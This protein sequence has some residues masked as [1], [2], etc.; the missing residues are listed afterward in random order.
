M[1]LRYILLLWAAV[2]AGASASRAVPAAHIERP[3]R[4]GDAADPPGAGDPLV[5]AA[6]TA[7]GRLLPMHLRSIDDYAVADLLI[8]SDIDGNLHGLERHTGTLLWTL[9]INDPLVKV[10]TNT[11]ATAPSSPAANILWFVE[12]YQ[13]GALY[14]FTPDFGLNQLPTSIR[15]LVQESPFSLAADDK[16]YTGSRH[17][18]LYTVDVRTGQV[19]SSFG[20]DSDACPVPDSHRPPPPLSGTVMLGKTTYELQIHSRAHAN[21]VW[22]VTY[23][24]WGPNNIDNDL[25]W[26]NQ[27]SV[28]HLYFTPFHDRSLLGL[29][30]ES[31]TP[32]WVS[33]LP[34]LA[35]NVFD[36]FE[37][38]DRASAL[39]CLP[40]PLQQLSR[41]DSAN[42]LVFVNKTASS[43]EWFAMSY[44][45]YP[46]LIKSAPVS[47]F[48]TFVSGDPRAPAADLHRLRQ[49]QVSGA[50]ANDADVE[51]ALSGIHRVFHLTPETQY[52]PRSH[53]D[54]A[55]QGAPS[56]AHAPPRLGTAP[57]NELALTTSE[58]RDL[59]TTG[60]PSLMDG[61]WFPQRDTSGVVVVDAPAT[62]AVA[63]PQF[64]EVED[65]ATV[66]SLN[67]I[68]R[69]CEDVIVIL[70]LLVLLM[71][72]GRLG[73]V[74][75]ALVR[76]APVSSEPE[77]SLEASEP[78][79]KPEAGAEDDA[80]DE[81]D[82]SSKKK[83]K[84]GSRGGKRA[85]KKREEE[86]DET[87]PA[88]P[89]A[90]AAAATAATIAT[91][92]LIRSTPPPTP[93]RLQIENNLVLSDK[94][95]GY[96]SHGTVVF[97]GTFENRP[98]AVKRML[99][100]FFDI[101]S[102][103]VR[104]L[105]ESD[106]HPNVIRYFCSQSSESEKFLYIALE[107]CLCSLEEVV[108]KGA[109]AAAGGSASAAAA[110]A[111]IRWHQIPSLNAMLLQLASGLHYLHSLKI[112]HRDLKPQNI[113]VGDA[114]T[115]AAQPSGGPETPIRLLISDFGLC[116]KLEA[117][118]SSFRATAH[119]AASGT[120]GWRAPELLLHHDLVEISPE[121]V[122]SVHSATTSAGAG[123]SGAR[124]TKA[125]D[126]FSLGCVFF[127]ILSPGGHPFG[128]RYLREGNIIK[129]EY[130]LSALQRACPHDRVESE[131]LIGSM[132]S[133]DP[134]QRPD[135][136]QIMRHPF[137]WP[138][139]KRLEFL[140]RVSDRFE[141]ERRDPPSEL[142]LK[143]E[144]V[145]PAVFGTDWHRQ[146]DAV[147][148]D[149]LGKYRK[150][151][152]AKL[153]DLLRALRNKYH[154][155]NDMPA[156]LQAQ[157][158]PLPHRFYNYFSDRFPHMLMEIYFVV[159]QSLQHEH[160]FAEYY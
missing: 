54:R 17:T 101:A 10:T 65:T 52:Q 60:F 9:P 127:Y 61:I 118:Q 7:S 25:I 30:R 27:R 53:W 154:H 81:H 58:A 105:Q 29:D 153:M 41:L 140:L 46:T 136:S 122:E 88:A 15:D 73:P 8:V 75:R 130:D 37:P 69:I 68:K 111:A 112:V 50:H 160:V 144:A 155:F 98:V 51:R 92:P 63:P 34:S 145:A 77:P 19:A 134:R 74:V 97:E 129:G 11:T 22:N 59:A 45:N 38:A 4:A 70:V 141:V 31:G 89:A 55:P 1:H 5:S 35:V 78:E 95:L 44:R 110:A 72:F 3:A 66:K 16:I 132:I 109:G 138:P 135:T 26:Q 123:A 131:H 107:L 158:T 103:E 71:S 113:L 24:Q 49:L 32:A 156:E 149:N 86:D 99:L 128:D 147:F 100:D 152:P 67:L 137:F 80:A 115:K 40:H 121:I 90:P 43:H 23:S 28:D 2:S 139:A 33:R 142:L 143:L 79:L 57:A 12:P 21:V 157:M 82:P 56:G 20:R 6:D 87:A 91:S 18:S 47:V 104:L 133:H 108:E 13:D 148:L 83:R 42:D 120:S 85:G 146:M 64:L 125:I 114:S 48:E 102:H 117:D 119:H 150:Y 14:Y 76:K 106:D 94:I 159:G 116:K 96:G 93:K 126:I 36:V 124:L 151:H 39:V 84:R 62:T